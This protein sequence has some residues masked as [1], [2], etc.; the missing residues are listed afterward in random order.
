MDLKVVI[1][2]VFQQL[3]MSEIIISIK[4]FLTEK[5]FHKIEILTK[6]YLIPIRKSTLPIVDIKCKIKII[7]EKI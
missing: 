7:F 6:K 1:I 3:A 2:P 4:N 5:L